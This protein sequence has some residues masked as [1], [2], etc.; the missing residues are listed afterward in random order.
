M[1]QPI[2][3]PL[4]SDGEGVWLTFQERLDPTSTLDWD[5]DAI[6][7]R[8]LVTAGAFRGE[9]TTVVWA[10]ELIGLYQQLLDIWQ[11]FGYAVQHRVTLQ[12]G[13][14]SISIG[15]S[16]TGHLT[17]VIEARN[18]PTTETVLRFS[19]APEYMALGHWLHTLYAVLAAF[20]PH[21]ATQAIPAPP[22][23]EA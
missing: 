11:N 23:V 22:R 8:V 18:D 16:R 17:L 6:V 21:V 4:V 12:E 13:T 7:T 19:L 5:R 20:P 15:V 10:H 2:T 9:F 14:L 3:L 1:E